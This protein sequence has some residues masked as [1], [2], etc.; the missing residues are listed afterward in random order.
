LS[1]ADSINLSHKDIVALSGGACLL[2]QEIHDD[3]PG[4]LAARSYIKT[5]VVGAWIVGDIL[6]EEFV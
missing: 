1:E 6:P 2:Y 3:N 4:D 5:Y